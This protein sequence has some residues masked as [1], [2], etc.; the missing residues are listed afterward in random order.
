MGGQTDCRE[1]IRRNPFFQQC[2][3]PD[4]S[5]NRKIAE[6]LKLP[7]QRRDYR[8]GKSRGQWRAERGQRGWMSVGGSKHHRNGTGGSKSRLT[9]I[10]GHSRRFSA[11]ASNLQRYAGICVKINVHPRRGGA[12]LSKPND[13]H[14]VEDLRRAFNAFVIGLVMCRSDFDFG[15]LTALSSDC[16]AARWL[17]AFSILAS[18][19]F[20]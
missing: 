8:G 3:K 1:K 14:D 13:D 7:G 6:T 17:S 12:R 18:R 9:G 16:I 20:I 19:L 2:P 10:L 11:I 15:I 5:A 4:E